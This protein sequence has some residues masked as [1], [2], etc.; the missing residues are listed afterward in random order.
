MKASIIYDDVTRAANTNAIAPGGSSR[1]YGGYA[2]VAGAASKVTKGPVMASPHG[3]EEFP[4][5]TR[6]A[7][8]LHESWPQTNDNSTNIAGSTG[9]NPSGGK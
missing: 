7:V 2:G 9:M 4:W 6:L 3:L 1:G 5:L 8:P